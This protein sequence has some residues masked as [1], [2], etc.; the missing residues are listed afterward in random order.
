[1]NDFAISSETPADFEA[2]DFKRNIQ[3]KNLIVNTRPQEIPNIK[4]Q[5]NHQIINENKVYNIFEERIPQA[6]NFIVKSFKLIK[7][8]APKYY[9]PYEVINKTQRLLFLKEIVQ[10]NND[11]LPTLALVLK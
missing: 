10:R 2:N 7:K 1:M 8:L 4:K 9:G 11:Q 6:S 5:Q 3:I